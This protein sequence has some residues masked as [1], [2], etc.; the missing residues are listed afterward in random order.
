[1]AS[2]RLLPPGGVS[3]HRKTLVLGISSPPEALGAAPH[4][5]GRP[6][7]SV[8]PPY[9]GAGLLLGF[10]GLADGLLGDLLRDLLRLLCLLSHAL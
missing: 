6:R 5:A 2:L 4:H 1:M 7:G 8:S 3:L 10:G 9:G